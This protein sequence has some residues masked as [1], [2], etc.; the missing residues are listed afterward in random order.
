MFAFEE[1]QFQTPLLPDHTNI[2]VTYW[3]T[4]KSDHKW[5]DQQ[6]EFGPMFTF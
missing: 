6:T 3:I 1:S 4:G 5:K 2:G